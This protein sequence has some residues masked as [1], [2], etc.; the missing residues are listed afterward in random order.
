MVRH[1]LEVLGP[2]VL[3]SRMVHDYTERYYAGRTVPAPDRRRLVRSGW[4]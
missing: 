2:K 3:A 4:N 1:T